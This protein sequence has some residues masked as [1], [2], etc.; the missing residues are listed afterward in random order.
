MVDTLKNFFGAFGQPG[1]VVCLE[2]KGARM[3]EILKCSARSVQALGRGSVEHYYWK[4]L[5][6]SYCGSDQGW[7]QLAR[8]ENMP[9]VRS[10]LDYL[11]Q[12]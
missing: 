4:S 1:I 6:E 8:V 10:Q 12:D 11:P 9:L 3:L 2:D 7:L 5:N